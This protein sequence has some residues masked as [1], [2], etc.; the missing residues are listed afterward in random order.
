[1]GDSELKILTTFLIVLWSVLFVIGEI[2][3]SCFGHPAK[4]LR[5]DPGTGAC[6]RIEPLTL[7]Q[8]KY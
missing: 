7:T 1:V 2:A 8:T 6:G 3:D 4:R 5:L